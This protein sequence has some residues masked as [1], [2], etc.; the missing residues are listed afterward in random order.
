MQKQYFEIQSFSVLS[1]CWIPLKT[2]YETLQ[3][4]KDNLRAKQLKN[5]KQKYRLVKCT[6]LDEH[7]LKEEVI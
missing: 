4:A 7:T 6:W 1:N 5:T 2:K 3:S